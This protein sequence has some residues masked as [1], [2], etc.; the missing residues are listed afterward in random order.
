VQRLYSLG[1]SDL[2]TVRYSRRPKDAKV[3]PFRAG[4][5]CQEL[6]RPKSRSWPQVCIGF[7]SLRNSS[8]A[9]LD[10]LPLFFQVRFFCPPFL[11]IA[12][13]ASACQPAHL[14]LCPLKTTPTKE[15]WGLRFLVKGDGQKTHSRAVKKDYEKNNQ[16]N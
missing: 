5:I 10:R 12:L 13:T 2:N 14:W 1:L 6:K 16:I 3:V 15:G 7:A 11:S 9:S 4:S 8:L